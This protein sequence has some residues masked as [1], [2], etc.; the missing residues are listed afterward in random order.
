MSKLLFYTFFILLTTIP[1]YTFGQ[2]NQQNGYVVT[3]KNDTLY[4]F[5][6]DRKEKMFLKI[7]K[8][9]RLKRKGH[10]TKKFSPGQ[11]HGYKI[12]NSEFESLWYSTVGNPF[13]AVYV[14]K[15]NQGKKIFMKVVDRGYLTLYYLESIDQES[16]LHF[17]IP[18][19]KRADQHYIIRVTQGLLGLKKKQ[20]IV[21][22]DDCEELVN[23]ITAGTLKTPLEI[24]SFYNAWFDSKNK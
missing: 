21:Y 10:F 6:I 7:Y 9:V 2:R 5:V 18:F 22:F 14:S 3:N 20:L 19:F 24:S 16:D 4:G 15:P 8:K 13:D 23:K 17:Y 1:D 11:L 12:E